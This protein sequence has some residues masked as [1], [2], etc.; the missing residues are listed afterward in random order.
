M[1]DGSLWALAATAALR[2]PRSSVGG[3]QPDN[4]KHKLIQDST[5]YEGA[6]LSPSLPPSLSPYAR[7][8]VLISCRSPR[9]LV[10]SLI[11]PLRAIPLPHMF[12]VCLFSLSFIWSTALVLGLSI[13]PK[14]DGIPASSLPLFCAHS[15]LRDHL[16]RFSKRHCVRVPVA[17]MG[18]R[19]SGRSGGCVP[20][21][22][23]GCLRER[24]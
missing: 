7:A 11:Y 5:Q 2:G 22:V 20:L 18:G 3:R 10:P 15:N 16:T 13:W 24:G 6:A 9:T 1:G 21:C 14:Y 19:Q 17:K 23:C 4:K 12:L 8:T